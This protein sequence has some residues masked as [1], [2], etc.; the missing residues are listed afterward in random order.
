MESNKLVISKNPGEFLEQYGP[1][2]AI[3]LYRDC[4]TMEA[5]IRSGAPLLSS[6][7][8]QHG[9]KFIILYLASWITNL[10]DFLNIRS[11]MTPAQI[12]ETADLIYQDNFYLNIADLR[13]IFKNIK[14]G[15]YPL[16]E[17]LDGMKLMSIFQAYANERQ[18]TSLMIGGRNKSK[19]INL[20]TT[21]T[22]REDFKQIGHGKE[23]N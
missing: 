20:G 14:S 18:E 9:E 4:Y 22:N 12:M 2:N 6:T 5:C 7:K 16:F 10:N 15:K 21:I 3:K 8:R 19:K 23:K 13:L 1:G 11:K 17:S